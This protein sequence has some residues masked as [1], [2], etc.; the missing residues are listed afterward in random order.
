MLNAGTEY[1]IYGPIYPGDVIVASS[2]VAEVNER[3]GRSGM[4]LFGIIES[5]YINQH[6]D[7]VAKTRMQIVGRP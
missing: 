2:K 1:E 6:G 3:K 7:V 5:A 4:M